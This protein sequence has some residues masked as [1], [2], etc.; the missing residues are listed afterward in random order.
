M[1]EQNLVTAYFE[2][3][4]KFNQKWSHGKIHHEDKVITKEENNFTK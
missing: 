1:I 2:D 3:Y 4:K